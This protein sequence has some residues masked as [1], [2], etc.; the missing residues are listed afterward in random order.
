MA[1]ALKLLPLTTK[2]AATTVC[3]HASSEMNTFT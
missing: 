2:V 3:T 1:V